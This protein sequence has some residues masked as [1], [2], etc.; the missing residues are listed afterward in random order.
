MDAY[1]YLWGWG[2]G[3]GGARAYDRVRACK[4]VSLTHRT[5]SDSL[6]AR[7]DKFALPHYDKSEHM[8]LKHEQ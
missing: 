7:I 5:L 1:T 3:G 8:M 6:C 2:G 4:R